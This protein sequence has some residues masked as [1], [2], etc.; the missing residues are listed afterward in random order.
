MFCGTCTS[1]G[2]AGKTQSILVVLAEKI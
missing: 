1:Q 2:P